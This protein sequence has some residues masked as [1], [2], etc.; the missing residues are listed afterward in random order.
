MNWRISLSFQA[1]YIVMKFFYT[2]VLI[3][4]LGLPFY[5]WAQTITFDPETAPPTGRELTNDLTPLAADSLLRYMDRLTQI[6]GTDADLERLYWAMH[7]ASTDV[8]ANI[9]DLTTFSLDPASGVYTCSWQLYYANDTVR[10]LNYSAENTQKVFVIG[11]GKSPALIKVNG[12]KKMVPADGYWSYQLVAGEKIKINRG[13][14]TGVTYFP[15]YK[16]GGTNRYVV[17][18]GG[19]L[20]PSVGMGGGVGVSVST[21]SMAP[22]DA[23]LGAFLVR[24]L[25]PAGNAAAGQQ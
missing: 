20:M 16:E 2:V 24:V 6:T 9:Y 14:F 3:C 7:N 15:K 21:G 18:G 8:G 4:F 13:G 5:G 23:A 25:S 10:N 1:N 17:I 19:S 12:I 11:N 22:V